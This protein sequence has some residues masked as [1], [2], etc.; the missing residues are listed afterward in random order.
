LGSE[1]K[2][3]F[4]P[5]L[6]WAVAAVFLIGLGT[7]KFYPSTPAEWKIDGPNKSN[8]NRSISYED[9]NEEK[10]GIIENQKEEQ[11]LE[12]LNGMREESFV[13][14]KEP[15]K[16]SVLA[17][18]IEDVEEDA[19][20]FAEVSLERE[21]LIIS[22]SAYFKIEL[23]NAEELIAKL[24]TP[25]SYGE[26]LKIYAARSANQVFE[27]K[28]MQAPPAPKTSIEEL[29][30][31]WNSITTALPKGRFSAKSTQPK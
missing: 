8:E 29:K 11:V 12:E 16:R 31:K 18:E 3:V 9:D 10:Q 24:E 28:R 21:E 4:Y 15:T 25:T 1:E 27:G 13:Q 30:A 17:F 6:R 7:F 23:G 2:P 22:K 19:R 5:F 20:A 14:N 26:E